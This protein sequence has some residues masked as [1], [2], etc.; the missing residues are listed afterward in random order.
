M[1]VHGAQVNTHLQHSCCIWE[2]CWRWSVEIG[3]SKH[4]LLKHLLSNFNFFPP[5]LQ[6][7]STIQILNQRC[8]HC[9]YMHSKIIPHA[10][11]VQVQNQS[12]E[13]EEVILHRFS[14]IT[15]QISKEQQQKTSAANYLKSLW[16]RNS[17]LVTATAESLRFKFN[18]SYVSF[19]GALQKLFPRP[20]RSAMQ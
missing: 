15:W 17:S 8:V 9:K 13:V 5:P 1:H 11:K 14:K 7:K 19:A 16:K 6:T 12:S 18:L 20:L 2:R 4:H 3:Q 10:V